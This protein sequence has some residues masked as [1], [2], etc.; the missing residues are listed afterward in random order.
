MNIYRRNER[1][2]RQQR[3]ATTRQHK[4]STTSGANVRLLL[5]LFIAALSLFLTLP[6]VSMARNAY[7]VNYVDG[8]GPGSVSIFDTETNNVSPQ[9]IPVGDIPFHIAIT[10]DGSRAYVVNSG[11]IGNTKTN[12][13]VSVIDTDKN[14]PGFNTVEDTITMEVK[15]GQFVHLFG[16]AIA[17][18]GSRAYVSN[19]VISGSTTTNYVSVIDTDKNSP[20]FNTVVDEVI[21][22]TEPRS[23]GIAVTPD[24]SHVYVVNSISTGGVY[25]VSVINTDN[26][27]NQLEESIE[28]GKWP[29]DIAIAPNGSRAYVTNSGYPGGG[30]NSGVSVIDTDKNS[31]EFNT[32]LGSPIDIAVG[33]PWGI[34]VAPDGSRAYAAN[35][36]NNSGVKTASVINTDENSLGFNT[37][38]DPVN[39][40]GQFSRPGRA[41][42]T[43]DGYQAYVTNWD[44]STSDVVAIDTATDIVKERISLETGMTP[45]GIAIVPNQGPVAKFVVSK[46]KVGETT[47]FDASGSTDSD[48][49]V[50]RYDWDFGDN[51]KLDNAGPTPTHIYANAG[52]YTVTLTVTDNE[53]GSTE[54]VS[55]GRTAY[56]NG[57]EGARKKLTLD[58]AGDDP[59]PT[60]TPT[61]SPTIFGQPAQCAKVL[62]ENKLEVPREVL[63]SDLV[64]GK[65]VKVKVSASQKSSGTVKVEITG[66]KA[67]YFKIYSKSSRKKNKVLASKKVNVSTNPKSVRLLV[68]GR[69]RS[70]IKRALRLKKVPKRTKLKVSLTSRATANKGLKRLNTQ[71]VRALRR[72]KVKRADTYTKIRQVVDRSLCGTPL[73]AKIKG[74]KD[75]KL[76]A[77]TTRKSKKGKGTKVTVSCSEDC[78]ATVGYRLWGRYEIG[79]KFRKKGQ[80]MNRLLS[81]RKVKLKAGQ[82]RT[83]SLKGMSSKKLRKLLVRGA[84]KKRYK[85]IKVKYVIEARASGDKSA[86]GS[87]TSRV[88]LRFR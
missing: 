61:P 78:T 6:T 33:R 52:T 27:N 67:R 5:P 22:E 74:P 2:K 8:S 83:L 10:P 1:R 40:S 18:D 17:P 37:E 55:D 51:T 21:L 71:T 60:P 4:T 30:N 9:R 25:T 26:E 84:N 20:D 85:R 12:G 50:V 31:P 34:A 41:A 32:V 39:S 15:P 42:I 3:V 23:H 76:T 19:Y 46:G 57:G 11:Q 56:H 82:E 47:T 75:T 29:Y 35:F 16:I 66:R 45:Y 53:G 7:V 24:G 65:G 36:D 64:K 69:T 87:G 43:P 72:G 44:D 38:M 14:S 62:Y 68:K 73:K 63:L 54:Y 86:A 59:G 70:L 80:K 79:L 13:S 28:V 88:L 48:G 49:R 58:V 81:S 77:L